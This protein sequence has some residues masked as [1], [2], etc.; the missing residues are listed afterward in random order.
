MESFRVGI[1]SAF[2]YH[3][4]LPL[5]IPV[6]ALTVKGVKEGFVG[7]PTP[8]QVQKQISSHKTGD[9]V[10]WMS[11]VSVRRENEET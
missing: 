8:A 1:Q 3:A 2:S 11:C 5:S 6:F 4:S 10:T 7:L 9:D